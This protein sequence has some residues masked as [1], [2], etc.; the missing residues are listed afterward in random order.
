[1]RNES[2]W[3]TILKNYR[4]M[5]NAHYEGDSQNWHIIGMELFNSKF[6]LRTL[7]SLR[8][9]LHQPSPSWIDNTL[10]SIAVYAKHME[11]LSSSDL[12]LQQSPSSYLQR[13][14]TAASS[15]SS[16]ANGNNA[17]DQMK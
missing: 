2:N 16:K 11:P 13:P 14:G 10:R 17:F 3:V 15:A 7:R 4:L 5:K 6:N 8:I 12:L 9:Y 1:M